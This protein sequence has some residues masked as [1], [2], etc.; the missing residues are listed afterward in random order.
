[1]ESFLYLLVT[2][3]DGIQQG[4]ENVFWPVALLAKKCYEAGGLEVAK[5]W[6]V[7]LLKVL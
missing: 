7:A 2:L 3:L 6:P 4:N 1:L 5:V